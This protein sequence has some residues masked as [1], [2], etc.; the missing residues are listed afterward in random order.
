[1]KFTR[2]AIPS[3]ALIIIYLF[4]TAVLLHAASGIHESPDQLMCDDSAS[5]LS[6][7]TLI[8]DPDKHTIA[9]YHRNNTILPQLLISYLERQLKSPPAV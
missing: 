6:A 3:C 2:T 8:C 7:N 1:M 5:S 4:S 9:C